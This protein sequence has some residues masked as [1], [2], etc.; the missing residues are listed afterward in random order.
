[1]L[2]CP[3]GPAVV[4]PDAAEYYFWRGIQVP[5]R[6][7]VAAE[8]L[9]A[10]EI[11]GEPSVEA[12]SVMIE[13]FGRERFLHDLALGEVHAD[14]YGTLW[15]AEA[16]DQEPLALVEFDLPADES[17]RTADPSWASLT[18]A[19]SSSSVTAAMWHER[20]P[21]TR[22]CCARVPP[23][24]RNARDAVAFVLGGFGAAREYWPEDGIGG[25]RD[26]R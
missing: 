24:L 2:H 23:A 25:R 9:T 12:R 1:M 11:V 14:H 3:D 4:W 5:R 13:R 26:R 19:D 10:S 15:R 16:P 21:S 7:V 22:S 17:L 18:R 20:Y 6:A 8:T